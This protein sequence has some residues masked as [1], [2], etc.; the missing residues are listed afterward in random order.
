MKNYLCKYC[1]SDK[2]MIDT[3]PEILCKICNKKGHPHWKCTVKNNKKE[4]IE[5]ENK[6]KTS[7]I[8]L[9]PNNIVT[10]N[11]DNNL[12]NLNGR[13]T[14]DELFKLIDVPWGHITT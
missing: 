14:I 11:K 5:T 6:I 7:E 1:K 3:C 4:I 13:N 9:D 2:H 8:I 10:P 12:Y